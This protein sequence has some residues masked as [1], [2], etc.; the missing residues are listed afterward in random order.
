M[1]SPLSI[2]KSI[3]NKSSNSNSLQHP[4][5]FHG[6]EGSQDDVYQRRIELVSAITMVARGLVGVMVKILVELSGAGTA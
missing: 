3:Q 1:R 5:Y 6:D 2:P 4:G